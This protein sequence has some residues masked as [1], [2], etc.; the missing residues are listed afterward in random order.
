MM[1]GSID[2]SSSSS[3]ELAASATRLAAAVSSVSI[4]V[5]VVALV[6]SFGATFKPS[7]P[8][9]VTWLTDTQGFTT[10]Q[11]YD[12]IFPW[13][14]YSYLAALLVLSVLAESRAVGH[15]CVVVFGGGCMVVA[16]LLLM[17]PLPFPE[18]PLYLHLM[19]LDE[20]AVGTAFASASVFYSYLL[21]L[22][23]PQYYQTI[24]RPSR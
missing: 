19:Q 23:R 15:R 14:T 4:V 24:V 3:R 18:H 12:D 10:R 7:E 11:V 5:A 20:L 6:Y 17:L 22:A 13:W 9:L 8:Y 16:S 21:L 1:A 2:S